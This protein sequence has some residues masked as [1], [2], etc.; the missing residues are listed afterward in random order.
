MTGWTEEDS[1]AF[2]DI[3]AVAVPRRLEMLAT[4]IS[5][6]PF[7]PAEAPR[8]VELGAGDGRLASALLDCFP[9]ATLVA[10][11][12]SESMRKEA[13]GRLAR[14][15]DRA[16]VA[17]FDLETLDWWEVIFGADVVV[18]S[19][20]LHHLNDAKKQYVYKAVADRISERGALLIADMV[21]PS[22]EAGRALAAD[23]WDASVREQ[24]E[25]LGTPVLFQRFLDAKW[26]HFRFPDVSDQPSALFHHLVWLKHAGF[27]VVDCWWM[28]GGHA[29]FGGHKKADSIGGGVSYA[30]ALNA[31][32]IALGA[33][34]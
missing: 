6:V 30:D 5:L 4:T 12:G 15:G 20:A 34:P 3:A 2:L 27:G 29:V 28:F 26:N 11:D 22:H 17:P 23:A 25:S 7:L 24:S 9:E 31:L 18:S 8:I 32:R 1:R 10:L 33:R 14:F 19:L 21:E 13:G 16:R